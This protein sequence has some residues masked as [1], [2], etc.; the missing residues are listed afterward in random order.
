MRKLTITSENGSSML[1][2]KTN[3]YVLQVLE[4]TGVPDSSKVSL[5]S[6]NQDGSTYIQTLLED[7]EIELE[8]GILESD[9]PTLY[10]LKET[11]CRTLNPKYQ[12]DILYEYPGGSKRI[13]G[14]L[15]GPVDFPEGD[16]IGYQ[17]AVCT[18]ECSNPFWK[19]KDP[20]GEK[21]AVSVPAFHFPLRFAPKTIFSVIL[22]K[23]IT[24]DVKGHVPTPINIK[25]NGPADNPS[26][27]NLTTGEFVKVNKSLA[28]GEILEINTALGNKYV[29]IDGK[30]A[31]G[32]IDLTTT[33]FYLQPGENIITYDADSG[34]DSA[35]VV[36][37]Y[38][39][40][41][42]GV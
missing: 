31:F 14:V 32:F 10:A 35:E 24:I 36:L 25:F 28:E 29:R 33:F 26:V 7:R 13:K 12:L 11:V 21:L 42:M 2:S 20:T 3:P 22:N 41:Y 27:T 4:G 39:N 37:T 15:A 30:N 6:P 38:N 17:K 40:W 23:T 19:D 18:I 1:I 5:K 34:S 9:F 16:M 8:F